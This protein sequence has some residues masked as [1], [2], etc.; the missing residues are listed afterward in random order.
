[1][2]G[3]ILAAALATQPPIRPDP[4][5][6]PG[7]VEPSTTLA[8]VC[9]DHYDLQ[10]GVRHVTA[11]TKA[12]V[13]A[14]YGYDRKRFGPAEV[15]HLIS[16]VLGGSNDVRNLWPESYVSKPLNAHVKDQ[17]EV[18]LHKLTCAGK[19]PLATAQKA[20]SADWVA[21]YQTYVG[22]LPH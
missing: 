16:I 17:L 15:D 4:N 10:P 7:V 19:V 8:K 18:A 20:I 21:A 2:L 3:L 13:Y 5:L 9:V 12:K 22:P 1:M 14:E 11:A 6:T